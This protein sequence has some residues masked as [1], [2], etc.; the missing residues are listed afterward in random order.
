MASISVADVL[1]PGFVPARQRAWQI[2]RKGEP[3][4][5]LVLD[6]DVPI[7]SLKPGEV[8]VRVEAVS[9]HNVSVSFLVPSPN[10]AC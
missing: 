10:A 2:V 6:N 9:F 7:P 1:K 8:L 4:E 5:A 3:P